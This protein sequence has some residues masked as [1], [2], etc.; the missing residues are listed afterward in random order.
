TGR[1]PASPLA[2]CRPVSPI[3]AR[4]THVAAL[5]ELERDRPQSRWAWPLFAKVSLPFVNQLTL[6]SRVVGSL[7]GCRHAQA[8]SR[9]LLRLR[10]A[11]ALCHG[12]RL[13]RQGLGATRRAR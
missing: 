2:G 8:R 13:Y 7:M 3:A 5:A 1:Y 10:P 9:V 6:R 4:R 12:A 11:V